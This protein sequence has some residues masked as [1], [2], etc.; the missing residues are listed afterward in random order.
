MWGNEAAYVTEAINEGWISSRGRF[1][2]SF[3]RRFAETL[4]TK[5]AVA[6]CNGTAALHLALSTLGVGQGDEVI[7]PDFSMI[8]PV[9]AVLYCGAVPVPVEIDETWNINP[10]LIEEKITA[11]TR[12]ILVVHTYGHPAEM[13]K[14]SEVA[15]QHGLYLV[16]DVA[17]ALGATVGGR[18]A[19][20][21]GDIA[22]FS[23]YANKVV[24]TGEGGMLTTQDPDLSA[25]ARWK[26]D[27]CFGPDDEMRFTHDQIGFNYRLTNMQAAVGV[28]QMEHFDEAVTRKIGIAKEYNAALENVRG[29]TL[30]PEAAWA[31]NVYWVYGIVVEPEFGLS[32]IK[33]QSSLREVGIETRRFFTPIHRQPIVRSSAKDEDF[34][35]SLHLAEHGLYLP[36]FIGMSTDSILR[37]ADAISLIKERSN[38]G[39][40]I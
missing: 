7:V 12:A 27:L 38:R 13:T 22:C 35:R 16:E 10:E 19:G 32:R 6:V 14:I 4:D 40:L 2:D 30:P 17:E 28:A 15:R 11:K 36:S 23:F 39:V 8:S 9:L 20:T 33:L 31:K 24:T 34:P 1:V 29:L 3:E 37:V 21:F 18:K 25:K 26:R 5:F